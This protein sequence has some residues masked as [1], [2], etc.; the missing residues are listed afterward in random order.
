[1]TSAFPEGELELEFSIMLG[2]SLLTDRHFMLLVTQTV[3]S[4]EEAVG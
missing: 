2:F 3:S 1:M 4:D